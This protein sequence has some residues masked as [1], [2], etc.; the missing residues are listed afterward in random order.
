MGTLTVRENLAFSAN[1][2][3]SSEAYSEEVKKQKVEDVIEQLGLQACANT[4]V[5]EQAA[6]WCWC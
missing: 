6:G 2:R 1:L 3:L 5:S 4:L